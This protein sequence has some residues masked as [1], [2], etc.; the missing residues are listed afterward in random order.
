MPIGSPRGIML[1]KNRRTPYALMPTPI[2]V[3]YTIAARTAGKA[4]REVTG[5]YRTGTTAERLNSQMK[6]KSDTS[7]PMYL[8]PFLPMRF[9]AMSSRMNR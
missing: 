6:K 7:S 8:S 5:K 2:Q 4:N 9:R 1:P 3:T